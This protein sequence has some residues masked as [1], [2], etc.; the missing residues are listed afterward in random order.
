M[1]NTN[2]LIGYPSIDIAYSVSM[3]TYEWMAKRFD[4]LDSKIQTVM[5]IAVSATFA[6]PVALVALR[7]SPSRNVVY[8]ALIFFGLAVWVAI[9]ARLRGSMRMISP[10]IMY[11]KWL[12]MSEPEF[13]KNAIY[14]AGQH[15]EHNANVMDQKYN[16]FLWAI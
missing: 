10:A 7:L 13:K 12:T 14:F 6:V 2:D 16:F 11:E 3:G 5:A 4:A 8:A 1:T 15:F 9:H